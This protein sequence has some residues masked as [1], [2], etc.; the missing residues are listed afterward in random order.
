M[1][2]QTLP[3]SSRSSQ[4]LSRYER[5][6]H[7]WGVSRPSIQPSILAGNPNPLN[8]TIPGE[9]FYFLSFP[10]NLLFGFLFPSLLISNNPFFTQGIKDLFCFS[11][12]DG[13]TYLWEG[14]CL[15]SCPASTLA[16]NRTDLSGQCV[17]CHYSCLSCSGPSDSECTVCHADSQLHSV[18]NPGISHDESHWWY[19][20]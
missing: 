2:W 16:T 8:P 1:T 17:P 15:S 3:Y 7:L 10:F 11:V 9:W 4:Y 19:R 13:S 14:K 18:T 12:C 20:Q 6:T 5:R